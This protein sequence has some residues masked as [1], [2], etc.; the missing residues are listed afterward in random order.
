[1]NNGKNKITVFMILVIILLNGLVLSYK[2][3]EKDK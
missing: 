3:L 2:Y 1:M